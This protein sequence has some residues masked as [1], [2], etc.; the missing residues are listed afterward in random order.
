MES[1]DA[2]SDVQS[3]ADAIM[4]LDV[5]FLEPLS[6][7]G[8]PS[9]ARS[10]G[11]GDY[12]VDEAVADALLEDD[13]LLDSPESFQEFLASRISGVSDD[14]P[15]S[16]PKPPPLKLVTTLSEVPETEVSTPFGDSVYNAEDDLEDE[17]LDR[18]LYGSDAQSSQADLDHRSITQTNIGAVSCATAASWEEDIVDQI[19]ELLADGKKDRVSFDL[20]ADACS[21]VHTPWPMEESST[22]EYAGSSECS[23]IADLFPFSRQASKAS[24]ASDRFSP[25]AT[26]RQ[27]SFSLVRSTAQS[28]E[29]DGDVSRQTTKWAPRHYSGLDA[30]STSTVEV[31]QRSKG[32]ASVGSLGFGSVAMTSVA[33]LSQVSHDGQ[34]VMAYAPSE[35][36]TPSSG[37]K[38]T[39]DSEA[40]PALADVGS[41]PTPRPQGG[42]AVLSEGSSEGPIPFGGL[43]FDALS[44]ASDSLHTV[45]S[46]RVDVRAPTLEELEAMKPA[47]ARD[48]ES[49]SSMPQQSD[50]SSVPDVPDETSRKAT[51]PKYALSESD[52]T[53][54]PKLREIQEYPDYDPLGV[55]GLT[56]GLKPMK[57]RP[58]PVPTKDKYLPKLKDPAE[59]AKLEA[60]RVMRLNMHRSLQTPPVYREHMP[61]QN[62]PAM[63]EAQEMERFQSIHH[64]DH[65][66]PSVKERRASIQR[67]TYKGLAPKAESRTPEKASAG[68]SRKAKEQQQ[69]QPARG[70]A[71]AVSS[72]APP[73]LRE[74]GGRG[75][76]GAA[77]AAVASAALDMP[78]V[79]GP[80]VSGSGRRAVAGLKKERQ[81]KEKLRQP[82]LQETLQL[83]STQPPASPN[84]ATLKQPTGAS[85]NAAPGKTRSDQPLLLP[86]MTP[87]QPLKA[88]PAASPYGTA[89]FPE[90]KANKIAKQRKRSN[91]DGTYLVPLPP[92][93]EML[94]MLKKG[95]S[96]SVLCP[97][98]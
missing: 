6:G 10:V 4:G 11:T 87:S 61:N 1:K 21:S 14:A 75:D 58:M 95:V 34:D 17:V 97:P 48:S 51:K 37:L 57:R 80:R 44:A 41:E 73:P 89:L 72:A 63:N 77:V 28:E 43:A 2:V 22:P 93:A 83:P 8:T 52:G 71:P 5:E 88:R 94:N 62:S 76:A 59:V 65:Y 60:K 84:A 36:N 29:M 16:P 78:K 31:R 55:L 66:D 92:G 70:Q 35:A 30:R 54:P 98:I 27:H 91:T 53:T 46:S 79:Q 23:E 7:T 9:D 25:A 13:E 64:R 12:D 69:L 56:Y 39:V 24:A 47:S 90:K 18:L 32:M 19:A 74:S 85:R 86:P 81:I 49:G 38:S 40:S 50:M 15:P 42:S 26:S 20:D 96:P 3:L 82:P 68:P 33:A 45:I 67:S